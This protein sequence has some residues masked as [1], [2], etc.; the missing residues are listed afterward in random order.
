MEFL[1]NFLS[2]LTSKLPGVIGA[3][4]VL[5]IGLIVAGAVG[6]LVTRLLAKTSLD[7]KILGK[8]NLTVKP[9]EAVG[10]LVYYFLVL[11]VLMAVL[12]MLGIS[13]VLEPLKTMASKFFAFIP[14]VIAA[15]V[16]GYAGY[17]LATIVSSLVTTSAEFF[18]R[19]SA[20][21]GFSSEINL[22]GIVRQVVFIIIFIPILIAALDALNITAISEPAKAMLSTLIDSIPNIIATVLIVGAFYI[23][24]KYVSVLLKDVL[25]SLNVDGLGDKLGLG[26]MFGSSF[27]LSKLTADLAFFFIIL[28]GVMTGIDKLGFSQLTTIL[29]SVLEISGKLVFGLAIM[30]VGTFAS[31]IIFNALAKSEDSKFMAS[32]ARVAALSLFLAMGLRAMGIANDIVNLAFGLLLGAVAVA[33]AVAFGIGGKETAGR[34]WSDFYNK[35][36]K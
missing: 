4:V 8:A 11:M 17:I 32:I 6:R 14:N 31:N 5:F 27:K 22:L 7:N 12:E 29:N 2:T 26:N 30:A 25:K 24:G 16:I 28:T 35:I 1:T 19:L 9:E 15:G 18:T 10:K 3:I 36:K 13:N 33:I 21:F 20:K 23:G 34:I